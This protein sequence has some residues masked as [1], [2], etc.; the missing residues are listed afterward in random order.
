MSPGCTVLG[1]Q[2]QLRQRACRLRVV[3]FLSG[4]CDSCQCNGISL[5]ELELLGTGALF[6][7]LDCFFE[8][9]GFRLR[10]VNDEHNRLCDQVK[11]Q[12]IQNSSPSYL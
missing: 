1:R 7:D 4:T 8:E 5:S 6:L 3:D 11:G 2:F 12:T 9:V 10:Y